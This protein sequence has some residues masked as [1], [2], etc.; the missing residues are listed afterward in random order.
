[1]TMQRCM[2]TAL[3]AAG[4]AWPLLVGAAPRIDGIAPARA[5]R[6]DKPTGPIVVEHRIAARPAVGVPVKIA[7]TARVE[8]EVG[9]LSIEADATVPRAAVVS[10]PVLV[11]A[12]K[13]VYSWEITIVPLVADA[14]YLSVIVAGS[15]DG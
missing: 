4:L 15:I 14:G 3:V 1:M 7:I 9:R 8:G 5:E 11:A 6:P 13:G 10:S 2:V 12:G